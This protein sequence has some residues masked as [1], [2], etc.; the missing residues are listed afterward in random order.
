M[1]PRRNPSF[2]PP[3]LRE[4]PANCLFM[5]PRRVVFLVLVTA[6]H[7]GFGLSPFLPV[8]YDQPDPVTDFY[9]DPTRGPEPL[10]SHVELPLAEW[11]EA[12]AQA[13]VNPGN[14]FSDYGHYRLVWEV[15]FS[16]WILESGDGPSQVSATELQEMLQQFDPPR[17]WRDGSLIRYSLLRPPASAQAPQDGWPLII[18]NPGVGSIGSTGMSGNLNDTVAWASRYH[19]AHYPAYVILWHPQDR[20]TSPDG[21]WGTRP[22]AA[23]A[24]ALEVIDG[25]VDSHPVD[26]NRIYVTGFSMGGRTTWQNLIDR[27][28]FFAA[29]IPH[30]GAP[31][32]PGDMAA[33]QRIRHIPIWMMM[34][35]QDPWQGSARYIRAYQDLIDAGAQRVRFWEIQDLE[36]Q[37][38]PLRS[39]HIPEWLFS[40]SLNDA[41]RAAP[42][43]VLED[44][45]DLTVVEGQRVELKAVFM[46]AP[47]PRVQWRRD[48][49]DIPAAEGFFLHIE[50]VALTDA[51]SYSAVALNPHGSVASAAARLTVL[52]DTTPPQLVSV[53]A[54][55]PNG[56]AVA[57]DEPV[58]VDGAENPDTYRLAPGGEVLAAVI[59]PD[60]RTVLLEVAGL[61]DGR[62]YTLSVMP[63]EDR[64]ANPNSSGLLQ[65]EFAFR[66][67]LVGHWRLDE[68]SGL[69]ALDSS[70]QGR[71]GTLAE[72]VDWTPDGRI[73]GAR[74]FDGGSPYLDLP[75][76]A[77][78]PQAGTFSLWARR[79]G[80][81]SAR[82]QAIASKSSATDAD[83]RLVINL[84]QSSGFLSFGLGDQASISAA[85]ALGDDWAHLAITWEDGQY[86][87]HVNGEQVA[88]GRYGAFSH[89]GESMRIG[90]RA[91]GGQGF[92]G[93]V[94][95]IRLYNR[96]LSPEALN[97]LY[98]E[99]ISPPVPQIQTAA[100]RP[101]G[102]VEIVLSTL[103]G[104]EYTLQQ[105][106]DPGGA[107]TAAPGAQFVGDGGE[108][109]FAAAA[110][111]APAL[112]LRITAR[113]AD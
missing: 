87:C 2:K 48:G 97:A 62:R 52:P 56:L 104:V 32:A 4:K 93:A 20:M 8:P 88:S 86:R 82:R 68:D 21:R 76:D 38:Y 99:G 110:D 50:P 27:P 57:F 41:H 53:A 54:A 55:G 25:F 24:P 95:D 18:V 65:R 75:M 7:N 23:Y 85:T 17:D 22:D 67:S 47:A 40:H 58:A 49:A 90:N 46:G 15:T 5:N 79:I 28:D 109:T 42:P 64:A 9:G 43:S 61:A 59:Q 83:S 13:E 74:V 31:F 11:D 16:P 63:V 60:G 98:L 6:L 35:N 111:H 102:S 101:D 73:D 19:R 89:A 106:A 77:L 81:G 100:I 80:E 91:Q 103:E 12:R 44:P 39:F 72:R 69:R 45:V 84:T 113:W 66:P 29:A 10:P 37:D 14:P 30:A 71:D 92:A 112:F 96:A 78:E 51:G 36:H 108:R 34:G 107:W 94:D 26:R 1:L 33:A 3:H 105:A 70:G